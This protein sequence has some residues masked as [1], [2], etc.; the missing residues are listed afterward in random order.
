MFDDSHTHSPQWHHAPT[1]HGHSAALIGLSHYKHARRGGEGTPPNVA[2]AQCPDTYRGVHAGSEDAGRLYADDVRRACEEITAR[3]GSGSLAAFF[4][5]SIVG[6]AGQMLLPD[7][8][9]RNAYALVREAGGV[10]VADEVQT[11]FGRCGTDH[12]WAFELGGDD[13][14][15]DIV[16]LGKPAGNG[17]PLAAVVTTPAIAAR[18]DNGMEYFNTFGGNPVACSVGMVRLHFFST[19]CARVC[20]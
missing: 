13:V 12:F 5:E 11:G 18:F 15:P 7:G 14:V 10:C 6:C 3:S 20:A 19:S 8:Y 9:L 4:C 1:Q 17:Y 2:L 16:T